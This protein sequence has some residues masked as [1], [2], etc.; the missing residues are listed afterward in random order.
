[1]EDT[2]YTRQ[3]RVTKLKTS[4]TV[5]GQPRTRV[6][7][8]VPVG[9]VADERSISSSAERH[10]DL[11]VA[12]ADLVP[13]VVALLELPPEYEDGMACT[14]ISYT[15]KDEN[16]GAVVT[17]QKQLD[18]AGVLI[19]NTPHLPEVP[20]DEDGRGPCL[21]RDMADQLHTVADEA[22]AYATGKKRAQGDL[23]VPSEAQEAAAAV[24]PN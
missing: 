13:H 18:D 9:E 16:M 4:R 8:L 22:L 2:Q 10:T 15:D 23:F 21:P 7:W 3:T 12:M 20:Y 17:C 1:M 14:G 6:E 24:S 5:T 19:L 11:D